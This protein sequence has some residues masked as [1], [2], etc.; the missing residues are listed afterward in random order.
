MR[1]THDRHRW[2]Q[3]VL[4]VRFGHFLFILNPEHRG[5]IS[6]PQFSNAVPHHGF[7]CCTLNEVQMKELGGRRAAEHFGVSLVHLH[8]FF[9]WCF[10]TDIPKLYRQS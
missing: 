10:H 1:R 4:R 5:I 3:I 9:C 2:L 7:E 8:L 6:P